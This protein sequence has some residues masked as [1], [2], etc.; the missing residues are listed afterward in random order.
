MMKL[1]I[2]AG[3]VLASLIFVSCDDNTGDI[4]SSLIDN[5]DHLEITADTFTVSTQ[6][7]VADSVL[8]R[9][10]TG[11][12]GKVRDPETGAYLSSD[13][14][15]QFYTLED[16]NLPEK[17]SIKSV[18]DGDVVAD[19]CEIRLY[20]Q[21]FYGDSLATMKL[22]AE[23][24][25]KPMPESVKYYS[26]FDPQKEGFV[27]N[28]GMTVNKMYTLTDK[29]V[30]Q[31]KRN[32]SDYIPNIC[33]RLDKE[34]VDK[35][36]KKYNNFGT[37]ILRK[38][39][40]NPKNFKDA[41]TF[42]HNIVPGFYF[43]TKSG[44]GSMAYVYLSQMNVYFRHSYMGS[45]T[46]SSGAEKDTL[47]TGTGMAVFPGTEEVLQTTHIEN[48]KNTISRLAADNSCTYIKSPAGIFTEMTLP[49]DDIL[50]N[51]ENDTINS[52]K[53]VL[54]RINNLNRSN[55]Y[56]LDAPQTLLMIPRSEMYS[57]FEQNKVADYKTSFIATFN[58]AYNTYSFNN[59][60]SLIKQMAKNADRSKDDWNKVIIIPVT[61]TT[62]SQTGELTKVAHDMSMTSTRLVGG[63][64][65]P[66][67][68]IKISVIYSKFK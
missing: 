51:H 8:S 62:N 5:M 24:L 21:D 47:Y 15:T 11:Y 2:W 59:I 67:E 1:K 9:N 64:Q 52:A 45:T 33:I 58:S 38:Y 56:A 50:K 12:L 18:K 39:Y 22:T 55:K 13:F 46:T 28:G 23:E 63:S 6:S 44:L 61:V 17:D 43:K 25:S 60:G 14:M 37:Y 42:I 36:G 29:N 48:D 4:G 35:D 68:P 3:A 19:S 10:V 34:Y 20:F 40:E 26:N 41:Y 31:S 53:V 65:N 49:V 32:E 57:F 27:R 16:F 30:E 54:T 66:Y 7:V